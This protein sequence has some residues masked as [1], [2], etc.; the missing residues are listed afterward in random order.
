[1]KSSKRKNKPTVSNSS[2]SRKGKSR[3]KAKKPAISAVS[4]PE[5][6]ALWSRFRE[7]SS[8]PQRKLRNNP[9]LYL[10]RL[11]P[12]NRLKCFGTTLWDCQTKLLADFPRPLFQFGL[13][14]PG[15]MT[16]RSG[17]SKNIQVDGTNR[18][19]QRTNDNT[20]P[21]QFI[22]FQNECENLAQQVEALERLRAWRNLVMIVETG[23]YHIEAWFSAKGMAKPEIQK[24]RRFAK[25]LGAP[26]TIFIDAHPYALPGALNDTGFRNQVIF[27]D[28]A[29]LHG[30][31]DSCSPSGALGD[32]HRPAHSGRVFCGQS[33]SL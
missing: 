17:R 14:V 12:E 4:A 26:D 30:R 13:V 23:P 29:A 9:E 7:S 15:Y 28:P 10:K 24:F 5:P 16:R 6:D 21:V 20:G 33:Q 1:M 27:W 19:G 25:V 8:L 18:L 2:V 32:R 11:L 31:A 3:R 22:V